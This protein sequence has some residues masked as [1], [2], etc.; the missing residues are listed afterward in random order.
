LFLGWDNHLSVVNHGQGE[1][2]IFDSSSGH[3]FFVKMGFAQSRILAIRVIVNCDGARRRVGILSL[4]ASRADG[5][6]IN[7]RG[8]D[9]GFIRTKQKAVSNFGWRSVPVGALD[10]C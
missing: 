10:K 1:L 8:K 6:L 7:Q 4:L 3:R 2:V 9:R 5:L